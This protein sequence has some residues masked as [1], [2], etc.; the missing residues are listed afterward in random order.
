MKKIVR[1]RGARSFCTGWIFTARGEPPGI[2]DVS[3]ICLQIIIMQ[4]W[5]RLK[6]KKQA[7]AMWCGSKRLIFLQKLFSTTQHPNWDLQESKS[8]TQIMKSVKSVCLQL[9]IRQWQNQYDQRA[10]AVWCGSKRLIF[11]QKLFSTSQHP[12]ESKSQTQRMKRVKFI[13]LQLSIPHWQNQDYQ[14]G[15]CD[16]DQSVWY[17]CRCFSPHLSTQSPQILLPRFSIT[18]TKATSNC[19]PLFR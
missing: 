12:K 19:V 18:K 10:R 6:T 17:F 2:P 1:L 4:E 11:L 16:V 3:H 5:A 7:R 9:S 8:Q 13:R 15:H 14:Q